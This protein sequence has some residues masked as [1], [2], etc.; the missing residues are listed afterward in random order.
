MNEDTRQLGARR[1]GA[2]I[3]HEDLQVDAF[4][5]GDLATNCYVLTDLESGESVVIDPGGMSHELRDALQGS[6][7]SWVILTHGHADHIG[8]TREAVELTGAKIALHRD[9]VRLYGDPNMNLTAMTGQS[10]QMPD[11]DRQ[12]DHGDEITIGRHLLTVHHTPGHTPG[13]ISLVGDGVAFSGD[14]LF[15]GSIGRTDL[16]G[17]SYENMLD[18][19]RHLVQSL[20]P[21][22]LIYPG[23]GPQT[24]MQN[25]RDINP[26]LRDL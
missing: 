26:Y 17:G 16:P 15:A 18:S 25:E 21:G 14:T 11:I 20:S 1:D 12:L 19:L 10:G 13:S 8:A 23:H 6:D 24:T 3:V 5:V 7:V 4:V 22:D 2:A 9:D